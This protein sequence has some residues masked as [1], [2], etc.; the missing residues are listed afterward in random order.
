MSVLYDTNRKSIENSKHA[1]PSVRE[2]RN[3]SSR[4]SI[5]WS[6]RTPDPQHLAGP[7]TLRVKV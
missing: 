7:Q 3:S 1:L 2:Q 6:T 5:P 4:S